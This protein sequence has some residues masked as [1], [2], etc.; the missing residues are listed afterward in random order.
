MRPR[1]RILLALFLLQIGA[2]RFE[3]QTTSYRDV[4]HDRRAGQE[5]IER[6]IIALEK[7]LWDGGEID[8]STL[9]ADDAVAIKH[10]HRYTRADEKVA[11]KDL[12]TQSYSMDDIQV[13]LLRH[14]VA[15]LTYRINQE[16]TF[17]GTKLPS[18]VYFA[19]LWVHR[20]GK[21]KNVF[22]AESAPDVI[23][24]QY[25]PLDSSRSILRGA[26]KNAE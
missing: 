23:T 4:M 2:T 18:P 22:Y 11:A 10:A 8:A 24:D 1:Y 5:A 9:V 20:G 17:R 25:L 19:S 26:S 21:W 14:G 7:R 6:Q 15:L 13:R 3:A 12:K 16:A